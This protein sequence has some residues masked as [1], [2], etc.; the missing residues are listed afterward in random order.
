MKTTYSSQT[1]HLDV[2]LP[3][4]TLAS[5]S[6]GVI[7]PCLLFPSVRVIMLPLLGIFSVNRSMIFF[8]RAYRRMN[9]SSFVRHS[10]QRSYIRICRSTCPVSW[11]S[12]RASKISAR[13]RIGSRMRVR[14]I[15]RC[16]SIWHATYRI[17]EM[18]GEGGQAEGVDMLE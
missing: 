14:R 16:C 13:T 6:V 18:S 1:I 10:Y 9:A 7:L 11:N 8:P 4:L 5:L 12:S 2:R 15:E 3:R 17:L